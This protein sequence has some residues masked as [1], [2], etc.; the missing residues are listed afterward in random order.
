MAWHRTNFCTIFRPRHLILRISRRW[1]APMEGPIFLEYHDLCCWEMNRRTLCSYSAAQKYI[2]RGRGG[3]GGTHDTYRQRIP[4]TGGKPPC[5]K[6][7]IPKTMNPK[8]E[9]IHGFPWFSLNGT[10]SCPSRSLNSVLLLP[11]FAPINEKFHVNF[12]FHDE[13]RPQTKPI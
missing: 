6:Q 3:R 10:V 13:Q 9:D 7:R 4:K 11:T 1:L 8:K 5:L 12:F 2:E